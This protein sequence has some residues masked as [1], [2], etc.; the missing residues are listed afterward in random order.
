MNWYKISQVR[1]PYNIYRIEG[2]KADVRLD[3]P[4]LYA[5][6]PEQARYLAL[7]K[8]PSLSAY[9]NGCRN[10]NQE[11]DV[12]AV[13]DKEKLKEIEKYREIKNEQKDKQIQDA[14]WQ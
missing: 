5:V 11:C 3:I 2:G 9:V 4:V 10:R 14:W 8:F 12:T 1:K 6:S 13:L 7:Q